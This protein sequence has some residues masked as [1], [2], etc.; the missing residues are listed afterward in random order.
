MRQ[1]ILFSLLPIG[2]LLGC[3]HEHF[4]KG[5]GDVGQF[6]VQQAVLRCGLSACTNEGP[7]I[8]GP[9]RYSEDDHG[10]I[11]QM[12]REQ[13]PAIESLLRETFGQPR[14]GPVDTTDGGRSGFYKLSP[15]GGVIQFGYDANGTQVTIVR[16]LSKKEFGHVLMKAMEDERLWRG[17]TNQ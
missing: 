5:R 11:I 7:Q 3:A 14:I 8:S 1:Y 6:I 4:T 13:Y 10:V 2:L 9:W 12:A 16:P 17:F 15:K